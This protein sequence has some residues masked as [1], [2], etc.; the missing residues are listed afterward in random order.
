[1]LSKLLS[2]LVGL[3]HTSQVN[4]W[5]LCSACER[6]ILSSIKRTT[7]VNYHTAIVKL[8]LD[9]G[10]L[11]PDWH[12]V[13]RKR[14]FNRDRSFV[15]RLLPDESC[16]AV[17]LSEQLT[18]MDAEITL[19]VRL[20]SSGAMLAWME[21]LRVLLDNKPQGPQRMLSICEVADAAM[22]YEQER[23]LENGSTAHPPPAPQPWRRN[24]LN[25]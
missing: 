22:E 12:K 25:L 11:A 7:I 4:S 15:W 23:E 20:H 3:S 18:E 8:V 2:K 13:Q 19:Y 14:F 1:M 16:S 21:L 5:A 6:I 17:P 9:A 10:C 24:Y